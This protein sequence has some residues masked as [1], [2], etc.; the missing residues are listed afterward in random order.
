MS[1]SRFLPLAAILAAAAASAAGCGASGPDLVTV[2]GLVT[3]E[4][5]PVAHAAVIFSPDPSNAPMLAGEGVTDAEG[6]Y[7]LISDERNGGVP[8]KYHVVIS[9]A[10]G[11]LPPELAAAS[12]PAFADDPFMAALSAGAGKTA[13][14]KK[15]GPV[16]IEGEYAFDIEVAAKGGAIDFELPKDAP[17]TDEAAAAN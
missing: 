3:Q 14:K 8:G 15:G 9:R 1:L 5:Q 12:N 7:R 11:E 17:K 13:P 10:A 6:R 2:S 16:V 4:G